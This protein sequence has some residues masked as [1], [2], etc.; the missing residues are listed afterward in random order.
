MNIYSF[1]L[2]RCT[3]DF[4]LGCNVSTQQISI[5]VSVG[6]HCEVDSAS[7]EALALTLA[8]LILI[9][10]AVHTW[11]TIEDQSHCS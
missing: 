3:G 10:N 4:R 9:E 5:S 6:L 1:R 7:L 8:L 11:K 2:V